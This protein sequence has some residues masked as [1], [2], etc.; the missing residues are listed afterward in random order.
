MHYLKGRY[1]LTEATPNWYPHSIS[2]WGFIPVFPPAGAVPADQQSCFKSVASG[3]SDG[4]RE[5]NQKS[6][7]LRSLYFPNIT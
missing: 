7:I 3:G 2:F 5:A 6:L 1:I 4:H